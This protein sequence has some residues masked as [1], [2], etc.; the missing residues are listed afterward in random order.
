MNLPEFFHQSTCYVCYRPISDVTFL[1]V[2]DLCSGAV[3][4][5]R[6]QKI[7]CLLVD[8]TRLAGFDPP[9]TLDRFEFG[10]RCA[11]AAEG[12]VKVAFLAKPEMIDTDGFGLIVARNRGF[13]TSIF[14]AESDA[15]QWL[16]DPNRP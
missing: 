10:R 16:L 1:Q 9:G 14:A 11:R 13:R 7:R 8:T 2:I 3:S 5:S 12:K 6:T 4:F 15:V